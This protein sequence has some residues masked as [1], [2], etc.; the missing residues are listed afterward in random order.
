MSTNNLFVLS[1]EEEE[2]TPYEWDGMPEYVQEDNEAYDEVTVRFR[3][4][5]DL[6]EFAK[7]IGQM[8]IIVKRKRKKSIWHPKLDRSENSLLRWV[9][10]EDPNYV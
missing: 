1:G 9:D 7:L 5:E 6:E 3:N 10:E 2:T 4:Q 8:N